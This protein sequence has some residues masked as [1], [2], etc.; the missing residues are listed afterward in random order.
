[1]AARTLGDYGPER[2]T[3]P[4]KLNQPDPTLLIW[5]KTKRKWYVMLYNIYIV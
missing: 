2:S 5:M 4:L 3:L 1:M